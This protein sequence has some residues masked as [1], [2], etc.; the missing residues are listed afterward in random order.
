M[1]EADAGREK[2]KLERIEKRVRGHKQ[3]KTNHAKT[4]FSGGGV[5]NR[6]RNGE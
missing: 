1:V 2:R 5:S 6:A 3:R 4:I